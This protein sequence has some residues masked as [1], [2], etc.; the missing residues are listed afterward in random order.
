[1]GWE[2]ERNGVPV[3]AS[4]RSAS[5]KPT[6]TPSPQLRASPAWWISS[7]TTSVFR[8]RQR[9]GE[10]LRLEADLGVG[11]D[12]PVV[13]GG[14]RGVGVA[15][16]RV[17]PDADPRGRVGPLGLQVLGR[18][19]DDDPL[20]RPPGQ[21]LGG[22]PQRERRLARAGR[23]RGEEVGPVTGQVRRDGL[24]LPGPERAGGPPRRPLGERGRQVGGSGGAGVLGWVRPHAQPS[25]PGP[26]DPPSSLA[27]LEALE[28]LLAGR[29]HREAL[30]VAAGDPDLAAEGGERGAADGALDDL[31]LLH[32]VR[33]ALVVARVG[34][35]D[36][37]LLLDDSRAPGLRAG[38]GLDR[39]GRRERVGHGASVGRRAIRPA[40]RAEP[41]SHERTHG[42]ARRH[43]RADRPHRGR[44]G[45]RP[46]HGGLH[47]PRPAAGPRGARA[48]PGLLRPDR[49]RGG[50]E[51]PRAAGGAAARRRP[52]QAVRPGVGD[53]GAAARRRVRPDAGGGRP[54]AR[55]AR[56]QRH[57][58]HAARGRGPQPR[59]RRARGADVPVPEHR[60]HARAADR[61][62]L[63]P[64][65]RAG[66]RARHAG[67]R[68]DR[69]PADPRPG[70]HALRLLPQRGAR[71]APQ[72]G[73]LAA[74]AGAAG[75]PAHVP[76]GRRDDAAS[77]RP[78]SVRPPWRCSA[79]RTSRPFAE[80]VQRVAQELLA[81]ARDG[82]RLPPF[83]AAALRECVELHLAR[84]APAA[85]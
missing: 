18:A 51:R 55:G 44:R 83:V 62:G 31:V 24:V 60:R 67:L 33:E 71:A 78:T 77:G 76:P 53:A 36:R 63:R 28:D 45:H 68:R 72:P 58:P 4:R 10:R 38:V 48:R 20:D 66:A 2:S 27:R 14:V 23:R 15:E 52:D 84:P 16:R 61:G 41:R 29:A 35:L 43:R 34:G 25:E 85:A 19:H 80:P 50:A 70:V 82:L 39:R 3:R 8:D 46:G 69:R 13:A 22:D 42:P 32:V 65:A 79:P 30:G 56:A 9:P 49:A 57:Q 54:A 47:R 37:A 26:P 73:R 5:S 1:M 11:D 6:A 75:P 7:S 21:Q 59:P 64:A 40:V 12:D 74:A 17:Q 81:S